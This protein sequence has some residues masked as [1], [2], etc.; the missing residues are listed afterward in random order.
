MAPSTIH[1][2]KSLNAV[3]RQIG[4]WTALS[5]VAGLTRDLV[6]AHFLGAGAAAD[7]F[8]V[9]FKLPNLFRRLTAEGA[10][11]NVFLPVYSAM[12]EEK[13]EARALIFASEV[14]T[15]L[16]LGLAV[17]VIVFEIFMPLIMMGLAPGFAAT[18]ARLEAAIALGAFTIPYL[19]M[20]SLVALWSALSNAHE[21]FTGGA[22]APVILN[23]SLIAAAF[24]IP[25]YQNIA[26]DTGLLIVM[27]LA[28]G[29]LFAG[30][31]QMTLLQFRMRKRRINP[32][33]LSWHLSPDARKMWLS[34]VPAALGAGGLQ[35]N[36]LVDTILASFLNVGA[37]SWLYYADR[38]AQLPLGI[39]GIA[40][41]TA[42]LPRLSALEANG[43][44]EDIA[45]ELSSGLKTAS[46]FVLPAAAA[47]IVIA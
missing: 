42:L 5:R 32:E 46:I 18:P 26:G 17:I 34:F 10:L 25:L 33:L 23:L 27:P 30:V 16:L 29:V 11:T 39:V 36:L 31:G 6:F 15:V 47:I 21:D 20:I 28:C 13:G 4:S 35:L 43:K 22:A 45:G 40:L 7:A 44:S 3:F 12:R 37:I 38:I 14:Q 1:P 8:L 2:K 24:T 19:P 41:G 9:A